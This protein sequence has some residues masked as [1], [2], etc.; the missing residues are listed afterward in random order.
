[1]RVFFRQ[2]EFQ[3]HPALPPLFFNLFMVIF[4]HKLLS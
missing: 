4:P 3:L 1:L 2:M